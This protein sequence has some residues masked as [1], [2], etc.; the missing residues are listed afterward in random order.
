MTRAATSLV[1]M[2]LL[3]AC[4]DGAATHYTTEALPNGATH[5]INHTPS[6][7]ADSTGITLVL[8]QSILP[9]E[10][11]PGELSSP[12]GLAV[13]GDGRIVVNDG[14]GGGILLFN[15]DGSFDRKIGRHGDGPGEYGEM[16]ELGSVRHYVAIHECNKARVTIF[17]VAADSSHQWRSVDCMSG[18][19][20][21]ITPEGALWLGDRMRD[22]IT[23]TASPVLVQ[24]SSRGEPLDTF[25]LPPWRE[26]AIWTAGNAAIPIP[27]SPRSHNAGTPPLIWSGQGDALEFSL[28]NG[29]GDTVRVVTIPGSAEPVLDSI[30]QAVV[31]RFAR[32]PRFSDVAK[33]EDIPTSHPL[34]IGLSVDDRGRLWVHRPAPD[35]T[36]GHFEVIDHNGTWLGTVRAPGGSARAMHWA[37]D[38]FY[39]IVE[40]EEGRP[41]VEVYRIVTPGT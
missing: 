33:L 30:R 36:V 18:S 32:S 23:G 7:W 27:Y 17:N 15:T 12:W 26:P 14:P 10:G 22:T 5:V 16:F 40:N 29:V 9:E 4:A 3:A 8:E 38:R 41:V 39:R 20:L 35:G 1:L 25:R 21:R 28:V 6:G 19:D 31:D 2:A 11:S 24:W 34:F 13:L 37:N